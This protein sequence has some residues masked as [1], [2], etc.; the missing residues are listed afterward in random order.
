MIRKWFTP[1]GGIAT[2]DDQRAEREGNWC[3]Y[4]SIDYRPL[5]QRLGIIR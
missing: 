4:D 5:L 2:R 1:A 3:S